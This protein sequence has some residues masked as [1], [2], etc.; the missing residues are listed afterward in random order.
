MNE[1]YLVMKILMENG[2]PEYMADNLATKIVAEIIP[3]R[4]S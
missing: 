2:I 4:H 3:P 1:H